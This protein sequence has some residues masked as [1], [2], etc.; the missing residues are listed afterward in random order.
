VPADSFR[1][2]ITIHLPFD[3]FVNTV[4]A[5][6]TI[7]VKLDNLFSFGYAHSLPPP[8]PS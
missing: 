5:N 4:P 2:W 3:E 8:K 6:R 1:V 7:T